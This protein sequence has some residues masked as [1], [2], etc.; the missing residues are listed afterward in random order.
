MGDVL[1][2]VCNFLVFHRAA[3]QA[4]THAGT[5]FYCQVLMVVSHG[6]HP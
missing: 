4:L 2:D 6:K 5:V 1:I 3:E